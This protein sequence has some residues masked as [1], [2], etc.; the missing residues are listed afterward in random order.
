MSRALRILLAVLT[1]IALKCIGGCGPAEV[2]STSRVDV[3]HHVT[4]HRPDKR[5]PRKD[6]P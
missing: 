6:R 1:A 2:R 3:D 4:I 5:Q